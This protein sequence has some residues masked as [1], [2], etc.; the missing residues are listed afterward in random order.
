MLAPLAI[1]FASAFSGCSWL[2][3][4]G[5]SQGRADLPEP[6]PDA[7]AGTRLQMQASPG[8]PYWPYHLGELLLASDSTAA[9]VRSLERAL[10]VDPGYA[11]SVSLLG[12]IYYDAGMHPQ[13]VSLLEGFLARNPGAP[14]ELRASLALHYEAMGNT[15]KSDSV[16]AACAKNTPAA[17]GARTLAALRDNNPAALMSAAR[18]ALEADGKSAVN[19][20]NY[21]IAL[22]VSGR[23]LE[24]RDAFRTALDIDGALPGALYNMAIVETFYFFDDGAGREWYARYLR[25]ASD[26]PDNLKAHFEADVSRNEPS[27]R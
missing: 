24:A 9:A 10:A 16:L 3:L 25:V 14:D 12:R 7:F 27:G 4:A 6:T 15:A 26:D 5:G 22:L 1:L 23:P 2:G 20:N 13:A 18:R 11:P 21:G 8:E 17:E 19:H